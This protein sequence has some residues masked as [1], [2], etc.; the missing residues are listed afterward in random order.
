MQIT[1]YDFHILNFWCTVHKA[2]FLIHYNNMIFSI[3]QL[4]VSVHSSNE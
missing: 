3:N 1:N 2:V 4:E